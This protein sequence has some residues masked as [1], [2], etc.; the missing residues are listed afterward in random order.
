MMIMMTPVVVET[1][2]MK[3][4]KELGGR[5]KHRQKKEPWN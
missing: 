2:M 5:Q 3:K 1:M 4:Y